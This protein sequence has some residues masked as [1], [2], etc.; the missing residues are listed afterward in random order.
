MAQKRWGEALIRKTRLRLQ[1][2]AVLLDQEPRHRSGSLSRLGIA[3]GGGDDRPL[4]ENVPRVRE[5]LRVA[6]CRLLCETAYNRPDA[7]EMPNACLA[8]GMLGAHLEQHI[9]E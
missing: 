5:G 8:N 7:R 3:L 2:L 4:H 1:T 9:D 6:Q